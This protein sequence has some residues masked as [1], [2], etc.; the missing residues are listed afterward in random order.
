MKPIYLD[1]CSLCRPYDDQSFIRINLETIAV[2]LIL[3]SVEKCTYCLMY[4]P[5]HNREISNISGDFERVDLL[6]FLSKSAVLI[7]GDK[8]TL[9]KRAQELFDFGLGIA[10][11]A[12]IAYAECAQADFISC[13]D[14]LVK[15]CSSNLKLDIWTGNP[16]LFCEKEQ[17]R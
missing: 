9:R 11:A 16:T 3:K 6:Y 7:E 13:D 4:S 2:R 12:H 15:K 17:L 1:V 10:D 8:A 5:V 14:K